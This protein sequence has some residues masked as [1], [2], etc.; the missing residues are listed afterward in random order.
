[1]SEEIRKITWV[2]LMNSCN[3]VE[4]VEI[5]E[6]VDL[7]IGEAYA[8]SDERLEEYDD[9]IIAL[10][11]HLSFRM[12]EIDD[13]E[14]E[15]DCNYSAQGDDYFCGNCLETNDAQMQTTESY[16][17]DCILP[18]IDENIHQFLDMD[19]MIEHYSQDGWAHIL[20]SY[21]GEG[22][23]IKVNGETYHICRTN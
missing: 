5:V 10:G 21:D 18:D 20:G 11:I 16:V 6:D 3:E 14:Y 1:M 13:I 23:E 2:G 12:S 17:E 19:R 7:L 4:S 8:E 15:Y 22:Y 9:R